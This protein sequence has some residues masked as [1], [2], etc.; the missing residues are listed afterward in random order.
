MDKKQEIIN[1]IIFQY[2]TQAMPEEEANIINNNKMDTKAVY[3][4]TGINLT[5][6][7]GVRQE[8]GIFIPDATLKGK[9]KTNI[10][11]DV[12]VGPLDNYGQPVAITLAQNQEEWEAKAE[13]KFISTSKP[14]ISWT[15]SKDF[16]VTPRDHYENR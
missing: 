15:N 10:Y 2:G 4:K 1:S 8:G 11:F 14:R 6:L 13:K 9:D 7:G 5:K 16:N 3:A 12:K